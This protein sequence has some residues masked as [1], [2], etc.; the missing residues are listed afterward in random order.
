MFTLICECAREKCFELTNTNN[1]I[2]SNI[3]VH[4]LD[5][6]KRF[7]IINFENRAD[8][9]VHCT[10]SYLSFAFMSRNVLPTSGPNFWHR[11]LLFTY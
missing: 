5:R 9:A 4:A 7:F 2:S 10:H 6:R 3:H 8:F 1:K 11:H